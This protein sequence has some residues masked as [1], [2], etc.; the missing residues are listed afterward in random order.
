MILQVVCVNTYPSSAFMKIVKKS[1]IKIRMKD[2]FYAAEIKHHNE[3]IKNNFDTYADHFDVL[4]KRNGFYHSEQKKFISSIIRPESSVLEIG[5]STG[6]LLEVI[7][8]QRVVGIEI[9]PRMAELARHKC[10]T[11]KVEIIETSLENFET[12]EKFDYIILNHLLEYAYDVQGSLEKIRDFC[13]DDS[14]VIVICHNPLWEHILRG[15]AFLGLRMPDL[16]RNFKTVMDLRNF[17]ELAGFDPYETGYR[18]ALPKRIPLF[19]TF[20][21]KVL[22]KIP[23]LAVGSFSEYVIAKPKSVHSSSKPRYSCSVIIPCFNEEGNVT[24]AVERTPDM[25]TFT[26]ILVVDDGSSDGTKAEAEKI[27]AKDPRVRVISYT[28]NSGKGYAVKV[29]FDAAKGDVLMILDA[30]MTVRPEDMPRFFDPIDQGLAD[31][32]NGTRMIYP[33]E[34]KAMGALNFIGNKGFGIILSLIMGR[35]ATDT[36]CGTKAFRKKHYDTFDMTDK[37]WGDFDLLLGATKQR[38]KVV[39]MPIRYM[40]R[41]EGDSKMKAFQHGWRLLMV[42]VQAFRAVP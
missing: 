40:A 20:F 41:V 39:E 16:N 36:L 2:P 28:P 15:T 4:Q 7:D 35:R 8:A 25:G 3:Q 14:R 17:F 42:C 13:H 34:N 26:E 1:K 19:T 37:S 23:G 9:S 12:N 21:N 18:L 22:A 29:G 11:D 32:V 30:D 5:C 33:M 27:A 6:N 31:F 10:D 24:L 38:L